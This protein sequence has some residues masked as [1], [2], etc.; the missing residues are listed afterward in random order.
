MMPLDRI[1]L[2]MVGALALFA[3]ILYG[4]ALV[5]GAV[6]FGPLGILILIPAGIAVYIVQRIIRERLGNREDD[7]Y[8]SIDR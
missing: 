1:M 4:V 6:S 2:Y 7:Y 8:D 5:I 3:A